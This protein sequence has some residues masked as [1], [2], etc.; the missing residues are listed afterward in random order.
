[1]DPVHCGAGAA[2]LGGPGEVH[3]VVR[4]GLLRKDGEVLHDGASDVSRRQAWRSSN[5]C[6][7]ARQSQ[8][9]ER[10]VSLGF[11]SLQEE[12]L[13]YLYWG[14]AQ[15]IFDGFSRNYP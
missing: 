3:R 12:S 1:M 5:H 9:G 10:T 11:Q 14:Q 6:K 8:T 4:G 13:R 2:V 15:L 7:K